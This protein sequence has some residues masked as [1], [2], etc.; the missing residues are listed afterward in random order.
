MVESTNDRVAF[1]R[2]IQINNDPELKKFT[3]SY[4]YA[5]DPVAENLPSSALPRAAAFGEDIPLTTIEE[6][7]FSRIK[8]QAARSNPQLLLIYTGFVFK[9]FA[10]QYYMA[11]RRIKT[12]S[13]NL[14]IGRFGADTDMAEGA[15]DDIFD[16][17]KEVMSIE[18]TFYNRVLGN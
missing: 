16:R 10:D 18:D 4:V 3:V 8:I 15:P 5:I 17:I 7:L 13:P 11:L 9:Q 12:I 6:K 1:N 2:Q 14:L